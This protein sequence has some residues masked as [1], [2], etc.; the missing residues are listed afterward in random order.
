MRRLTHALLISLG[1]FAVSGV[2]ASDD[3]EVTAPEV[4]IDSGEENNAGDA[5]SYL[6]QTEEEEV[7]QNDDC[8]CGQPK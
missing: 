7:V 6:F 8:N 4:A 2:Y 1:C 3:A 5:P